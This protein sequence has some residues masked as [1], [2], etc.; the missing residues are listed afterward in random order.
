MRDRGTAA[1]SLH[2]GVL[3]ASLLGRPADAARLSGAF[4]NLCGRYGVRPPASLERF[5][6]EMDVVGR[7]RAALTPETF[8]AAV[9]QGRRMSLD[10]AVALIAELGDVAQASSPPG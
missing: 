2:T 5:I 8:A 10:E 4:E 1:V 9:E 3:M 7:V 6:G